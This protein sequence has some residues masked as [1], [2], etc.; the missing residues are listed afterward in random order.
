MLR[1]AEYLEHAYFGG[2]KLEHPC[3][4]TPDLEAALVEAVE[5]SNLVGREVLPCR[6]IH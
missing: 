3:G 2:G 4:A 5:A 6:G 1:F